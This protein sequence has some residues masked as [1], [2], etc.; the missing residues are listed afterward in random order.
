MSGGKGLDIEQALK[1]A[2][3][4]GSY[5][6]LIFFLTFVAAIPNSFITLHF[7]FSQAEPDHHC[8]YPKE[9]LSFAENVR[10]FLMSLTNLQDRVEDNEGV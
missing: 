7:V 3:S 6:K 9:F 1:A 5:Q 2:G 4:W 8:A 10:F